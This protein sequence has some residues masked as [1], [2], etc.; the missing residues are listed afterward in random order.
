MMQ[1]L[2][3]DV[4]PH[5]SFYSRCTVLTDTPDQSAPHTHDFYEVFIVE[6]GPMYHHINGTSEILDAL[7]DM[8]YLY[9]TLAGMTVALS[10]ISV[11][12]HKEEI[13]GGCYTKK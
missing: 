9:S 12:P 2:K 10:D 4:F 5:Y 3:K 8:G 7:K 1:L 11:A 13:V 6:E